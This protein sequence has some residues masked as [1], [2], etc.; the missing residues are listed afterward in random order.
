MRVISVKM[1]YF[2]R[3]FG[4]WHFRTFT[5]LIKKSSK[6]QILLST[7]WYFRP[8]NLTLSTLGKTLITLKYFF[9]F[10]FQKTGSDIPCQLSPMETICMKCQKLF[11]GKNMKNITNM[12]SAKLA[13]RVVK[14]KQFQSFKI[15]MLRIRFCFDRPEVTS[16]YQLAIYLIISK[17]SRL[18]WP[19]EMI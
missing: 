5:A 11:S 6:F 18:F 14:V 15:C 4:V 17:F 16:T 8:T 19:D 1:V 12:T 9:L 3:K 13:Q 10:F 7:R 2:I